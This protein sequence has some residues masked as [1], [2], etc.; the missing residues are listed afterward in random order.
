VFV[1]IYIPVDGL[2]SIETT[3]E[4]I[5]GGKPSNVVINHWD[6]WI[7]VDSSRLFSICPDELRPRKGNRCRRNFGRNQ[8]PTVELQRRLSQPTLDRKNENT[9][10]RKGKQ[11]ERNTKSQE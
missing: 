2:G 6:I 3:L 8:R 7:L 10:K 4:T 9:K 5:Y 1:D 11:K